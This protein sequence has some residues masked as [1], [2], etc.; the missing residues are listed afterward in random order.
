MITAII[1]AGFISSVFFHYINAFY[2]N[3]TYPHNTFL[4]D[5]SVA[6]TD[7]GQVWEEV[8][9]LNPYLGHASGQYPFLHIV[10][11]PFT[12]L[13]IYAIFI[14]PLYALIF[15]VLLVWY[16][17]GYLRSEDRYQYFMR[18]LV[19]SFITY[20]FLFVIDRGN[21]ESSVFVFMALFVHFY[22]KNRYL[23]SSLF[24]SFAIAAKF[25]PIFLLI[26]LFSDKRYKEAF[27]SLIGAV[28]LT[29]AS[30]LVFKGGFIE[31]V[32]YIASGANFANNTLFQFFT[33]VNNIVQR[34]V[35]L[36]TL[37]KIIFNE[38][39]SAFIR[40]PSLFLLE[41]YFFFGLIC[42]ALLAGYV[43]L[44]EKVLWR[45]VALIVFAML[46]LPP[47]SCDYKLIH[48]LIPLSLFILND[49]SEK[50]EIYYA[51]MFGILLI[52]KDYYLL[53]N[54]QSEVFTPTREGDISIAVPFNILIMICM[55]CC[56][57]LEGFMITTWKGIAETTSN[58]IRQIRKFL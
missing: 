8:V 37:F 35:T 28:A 43:I 49:K 42:S 48:V 57:I 7:F 15:I 40:I 41:H 55:S 46:L 21:L 5:P 22:R 52:P 38:S 34:G 47:L 45:K 53:K 29:G 30:L 23:L 31:N 13:P 10:V 16:N 18:V 25:F 4:F 56:I 11:Y 2:F 54:V 9:D 51:V 19:F 3:L 1:I 12:V 20:P 26:L 14:Y 44:I 24:L 39:N 36:L 58:N 27:L 50:N 33:G 6:F 17:A 32:Q